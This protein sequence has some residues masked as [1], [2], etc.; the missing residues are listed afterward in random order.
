M[1]EVTFYRVPVSRLCAVRGT[2]DAWHTDHVSNRS[3]RLE[4]VIAADLQTV[5]HLTQDPEL[6]A[7]WDARFSRI[8]PTEQG[9][10]GLWRFT[11]ERRMLVHTIRGTGISL[12]SREGA[13]GARTSALRFTTTDGLSPL[14]DGRGYWRYEHVDGGVRF[15]TGYDYEPGWGELFD[16]VVVRSLVAWMTAASFARLHPMLQ[17]RFDV[18]LAG[19]N[20]CIGRETVTFVRTFDYPR[21][22]GR[23]GRFDATMILGGDGRIVDYLGTHQHL[24][25]DLELTAEPDGSLRLR[26][27]AQRFYAGPIVFRFPMLFS[28]R[29][30]LR[31]SFDD[32]TGEYVI[33][34]QVRNC[35]FGFLFGY[36]GRFTC[37]F[38]SADDGP[39]DHVL[40][41]Q[42][43][44]RE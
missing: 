40:P 33:Q 31:E 37:E 24:A 6:H 36:E 10:D 34:L 3:I 5:W 12:G 30:D 21:R 17:R 26:L 11:Y 32:A 15:I 38:P 2:C 8:V 28:G 4:T 35:V 39:P 41:L 43:E 9:D 13:G 19:G 22:P 29:A 25:V 14:R 18:S 7:R 44:R 1:S 23:P 20:G 42:H 16:R 27:D